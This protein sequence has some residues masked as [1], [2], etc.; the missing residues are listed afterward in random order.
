MDINKLAAVGSVLTGLLFLTQGAL[1]LFVMLQM[2]ALLSAAAVFP[3]GS[4]V[5]GAAGPFM[6]IGWAFGILS[7]L[8]GLISLITGIMYFLQK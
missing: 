1:V 6:I 2:N 7:L 8:S 5:S 3:G 4:A